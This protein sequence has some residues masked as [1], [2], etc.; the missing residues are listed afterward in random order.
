MSNVE[1]FNAPDPQFEACVARLRS[2]VKLLEAGEPFQFLWSMEKEE[3]TS[4]DSGGLCDDFYNFMDL[5]DANNPKHVTTWHEVFSAVEKYKTEDLDEV[6]TLLY[7]HIPE[8]SLLLAVFKDE[9]KQY[10]A[11]MAADNEHKAYVQGRYNVAMVCIG[12]K[13]GNSVSFPNFV[14]QE[15]LARMDAVAERDPKTACRNAAEWFESECINPKL[16]TEMAITKTLQYFDMAIHKD[17]K[18]THDLTHD[19]MEDLGGDESMD[20]Y[21]RPLKAALSTKLL[22]YAEEFAAGGDFYVANYTIGYT[23][24]YQHPRRICEG[25]FSI[26]DHAMEKKLYLSAVHFCERVIE[27]KDS[28]YTKAEV[29]RARTTCK[30][31]RAKLLESVGDIFYPEPQKTLKTASLRRFIGPE[32]D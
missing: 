32:I 8:E 9:Y 19:I 1:I 11:N 10:I 18:G 13:N 4:A 17:P 15:F 14:V 3:S 2:Y 31:A 5:V 28:A 12:V 20:P 30:D 26:I 29:K 21:V 24:G 27:G 16:Q 23:Q 22:G 25:T 6:F 7:K